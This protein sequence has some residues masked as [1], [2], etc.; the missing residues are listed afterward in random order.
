MA[1]LFRNSILINSM[2]CSVEALYGL[3]N[4]HIDKL[5]KV[6]KYL[7]K[8]IL[9][10]SS[11]TSIEALYLETGAMPVR[12]L[13]ICRRLMFYWSILSKTDAELVRKVYNAQKIS[14]VKND[15][16]LQVKEDLEKCNIFLSE[17]EI[18]NMKRHRFKSLVKER[19]RELAWAYLIKLKGSHTKSKYLDESFKIQHY[20]VSD[21]LTLDE[22]RLI[23]K[24]RT[25]TYH[26]KSNFKWNH[27][28][29]K[30]S[31][32]DLDDTQEHLLHCKQFSDLNLKTMKYEHIFGTVQE[33][34]KI[35]K[36][37]TL[38]DQKRSAIE[39]ISSTPGSQAHHFGASY[40]SN[41]V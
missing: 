6:D 31:F 26:C 30:C 39:N 27:L 21:D 36:I 18:S 24:F 12:F 13:I 23:F 4:T 15:W 28:D 38:I 3:N 11:S 14:P 41:C 5:E 19:V 9:D 37:L 25:H 1:L 16:Y 8:Q 2:L 17:T 10:A 34:L 33:Q 22:K 7:L 40:T 35:V 29:T 20:L 32:C